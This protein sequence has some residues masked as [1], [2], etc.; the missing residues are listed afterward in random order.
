VAEPRVIP[1]HLADVSFPDGHPEAGGTGPVLGF[2]VQYDG[3]VLLF[4]TGVGTGHP[5]VEQY[6]RPRVCGGNALFAG[7]PAYVQA[8][9]LRASLEPEYTVPEWVGFDAVQF[10]EL[11]GEGETEVAPGLVLVP[12]PGHTRGHQSL[13]VATDAGPVLVA[14]QAVYSAAEWGARPTRRTP[15]SS[16]PPTSSPTPSRSAA[17]SRS[18]C[19]SPTIWRYGSAR[20]P[21][22]PGEGDHPV[23]PRQAARITSRCRKHPVTWSLTIPTASMKA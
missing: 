1:L 22:G 13:V 6:Y 15:A 20:L 19:T 23:R 11:D 14:G 8:A 2:A 5:E 9:E 16:E 18:A 21:R 3:G 7:R 10:V 17:W 4:D 12:T